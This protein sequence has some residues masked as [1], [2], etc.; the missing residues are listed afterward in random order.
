MSLLFDI[1]YVVS[2][3]EHPVFSGGHNFNVREDF[4]SGIKIEAKAFR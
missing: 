2:V 1:G 3:Y 4:S